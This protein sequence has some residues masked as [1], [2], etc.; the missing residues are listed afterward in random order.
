VFTG[1][2]YFPE[3]H[4]MQ[5]VVGSNPIGSIVQLL[6]IEEVVRSH[7]H[8]AG[9]GKCCVTLLKCSRSH[10]YFVTHKEAVA[11]VCVHGWVTLVSSVKLQSLTGP[12]NEGNAK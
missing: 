9:L 4:S 10:Q 6:V 8:V 5:E 3:V 7:F 1:S 2:Q 11:D 12:A